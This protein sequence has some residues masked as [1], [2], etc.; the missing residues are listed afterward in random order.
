MELESREEFLKAL[1]EQDPLLEYC[2]KQLQKEG[3]L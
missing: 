3:K 1:L 2:V